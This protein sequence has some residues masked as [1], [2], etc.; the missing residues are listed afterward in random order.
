MSR[1][2]KPL[3]AF[4]NVEITDT[5]ADG[6]AV[7]RVEDIV[8]FIPY[9]VPGDVIDVKI[10][11]KKKN[12]FEGIAKAFHKYSE[13]R[14][15]PFCLHFGV[16]GGCKW[17]NLSYDDQLSFK[18][19]QVENAFVRIGKL[20]TPEIMRIIPSKHTKY[21]RNKIEYSF[22]DKRWLTDIDKKDDPGNRD[23]NA[24]GFH[25]PQVFDKVLNIDHC[26][27]QKEPSNAIR[28]SIKEFADKNNYTFYNA[29][30]WEGCLRNLIIRTSTTGEVMVIVVFN[31]YDKAQIEKLLDFI[32]EKF[33]EISSL[34]YIINDK[35]NDSIFDLEPRL[36]KGNSFIYEEMN[37]LKFKIGPKS[38]FQTNSEQ[39][40]ELYKIARDFA[41]FKGDEI[42]YDLYTGT[43]TIANFIA[44]EVK[45]VIGIE[46][47]E[48]AIE[49]AIENSKI[50]DI[51]NTAFFA[52]DIMDV[53][54]HDFVSENGKADVI[55]TDPPRSGMHQKVVEQIMNIAPE[56]I[57]YIS[58][59]PA[60]QARDIALMQ[61]NYVI[62][63]IQPV[64][65]FPHTHHVENVALLK[66]KCE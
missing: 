58:C 21:Y 31:H 10:T 56:K 16:C 38:F 64:D 51:N 55:I 19:K 39:A 1:K 12:Y 22:S 50:N 5:G 41:G 34:F 35:K 6:R 48:E 17:Q 57:V 62:E 8:I 7:A 26:Y 53:L 23:M 28:L 61:D 42:V 3:P 66:L 2:R 30:T 46:Y 27:L 9:V 47:I 25:V 65:M 24:L 43:G 15:E 49:D 29:R 52:G 63:K 37:G 20:Q 40:L 44:S 45:K 33:N 59:N 54:N 36:Y 11:R 18:Q 60:T 13:K 14:V 32:S 4:E